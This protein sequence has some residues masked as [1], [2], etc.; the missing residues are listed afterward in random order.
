MSALV[1]VVRRFE[2]KTVGRPGLATMALAGMTIAATTLAVLVAVT[3]PGLGAESKEIRKTVD[4]QS[5][6][7]LNLKIDVTSLNLSSWDRNQVDVYARI[8]PPKNANEEYAR[9]A[10]EATRIEIRGDSHSLTVS[11]NFDDVPSR[12]FRGGHTLPHVRLEIKAPAS[13]RL[14]LD[15]D[16]S[17]M[18]IHGIHGS[19]NLETDRSN[20]SGTDLTGDLHLKMDRGKAGISGF[21]GSVDAE[22]DRTEVTLGAQITGN[23]RLEARRGNMELRVPGSQSLSV[24]ADVGRRQE[25][26]TD[27][28]L[29]LHNMSSDLLEGSLNGGG[30]ELVVHTDR[31][32]VTLTRER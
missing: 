14:R 1:T 17:E 10:V 4:F 25:F 23:S 24:H 5:G 16:R 31:G 11:T 7:S 29:T 30:P 12:A 20:L 28:P 3:V 9:L 22:T 18:E 32:K 21:R 6:G 13:L 27:L 2:T 19:L 26:K 8:E 15:A